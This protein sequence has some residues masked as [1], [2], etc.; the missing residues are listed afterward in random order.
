MG[1]VVVLYAMKYP[2]HAHRIVQIGAMGPE[3]G[4]RYSPELTNED[5]T[6]TEVLTR[7]GDLQKARAS[8]EATAFCQEFWKIL[9]PLYVVDPA[10]AGRLGWEPCDLS[11]ERAFMKQFT[12]YVLPSIER[13][14]F[15]VDDFAGVHAPVLAIHGRL[16]RSSPYG[17]G[18]DWARRLPNARL[19]TVDRAAHVPWIEAPALTFSAIETFLDGAWP[20]AAE[21]VTS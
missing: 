3:Y 5:A 18:R 8:Y 9:R 20:G 15:T 12:E 6:F 21:R 16:D 10:D 7:L 11:N 14:R 1:L 2:A 4:R 17:A 13:L 19:L